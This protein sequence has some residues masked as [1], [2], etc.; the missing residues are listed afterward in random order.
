MKKILLLLLAAA[1]LYTVP[2]GAQGKGKG[3][4][5]GKG[6]NKAYKTSKGGAPARVKVKRGGPPPWAPAHGY[7][8]KQHVYFP[9]YYTFYDPYRNGYVYWGSNAWVF[10]PTIPSFLATIDLGR[11][12]IQIM[13][14]VPLTR[15]PELYYRSYHRLYPPQP[16]GIF[17]PVP[18]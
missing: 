2:A 15:H 6:H 4:G 3:H 13:G 5:H 8:A 9:D 14:D 1:V 17:V 7:R 16:V 18:R 12:R 10:S 11:A